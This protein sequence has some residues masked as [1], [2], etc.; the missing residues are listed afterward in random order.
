MSEKIL[1]SAGEV[2]GDLHLAPVV[3][4]LKSANHDL[5]F[6]GPGGDRMR[7]EGV[8]LLE[9]VSDLAVMGFSD[10]PAMLQETTPTRRSRSYEV[11]G[12]FIDWRKCNEEVSRFSF[13]VPLCLSSTSGAHLSRALKGGSSQQEARTRRVRSHQPQGVGGWQ[14]AAIS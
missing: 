9:H 14:L 10:I 8:E 7:A 12:S 13:L 3:T 1:V 4:E 5:E 2:S 11:D 6:F